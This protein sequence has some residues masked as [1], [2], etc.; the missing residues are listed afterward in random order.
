ME[1]LEP[2]ELKLLDG[3]LVKL[4]KLFKGCYICITKYAILN[5][6]H[7]SVGYGKIICEINDKEFTVIQKIFDN[8]EHNGYLR[9]NDIKEARVDLTLIKTD[10]TQDEI[11][12][13]N[14]EIDNL[15]HDLDK[16]SEWK[17]FKLDEDDIKHE[18]LLTDFFDKSIVIELETEIG[19]III[20][21]SILPHLTIKNITGNLLYTTYK[22][23]DELDAL[24]FEF[25]FTHFKM[26][27]CYYILPLNLILENN[28]VNDN[29]I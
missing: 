10:L 9:I 5:G 3:L 6:A 26:Y 15:N 24:L 20:S 19:P 21:K 29:K 23:N 27:I 17:E 22:F 1:F 2:K 11:D 14:G 25:K 16:V 7:N 13:I 18:E 4:N 12:F 28:T 8:I